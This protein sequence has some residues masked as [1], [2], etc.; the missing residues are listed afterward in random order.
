[1]EQDVRLIN[2]HNN[3][4]EP[5]G[6]AS[7]NDARGDSLNAAPV[8]WS[9]VGGGSWLG[10]EADLAS[11]TEY[12]S[13]NGR[14][15]VFQ[16]TPALRYGGFFPDTLTDEQM[17]AFI[18]ACE[19]REDLKCDGIEVMPPL[20][21]EAANEP[22]EAPDEPRRGEVAQSGNNAAST[23]AMTTE[24]AVALRSDTL[25]IAAIQGYESAL[26]GQAAS[27]VAASGDLCRL[28]GENAVRDAL[29]RGHSI[30]MARKAADD[31]EFDRRI[32]EA[33][34]RRAG[35]ACDGEP[36][37]HETP[38]ANIL[39]A[40]IA[41]SER[42]G[43][44]SNAGRRKLASALSDFNDAL[45]AGRRAVD[46]ARSEEHCFNDCCD[47]CHRLYHAVE[48][49]VR[50]WDAFDSHKGLGGE[51]GYQQLQRVWE[52]SLDAATQI[53]WMIEEQAAA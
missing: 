16:S 35:L 42:V 6:T 14:F 52:D 46:D 28:V 45:E 36:D 37:A 12:E 41:A 51:I 7:G 50:A 21:P 15:V 25:V 23:A 53:L 39:H 1:L 9:N 22:G 19:G 10:S 3:A 38:I 40:I 48:R 47:D 27:E 4:P 24:E 34:S 32:E 30:G 43:A 29:T 18:A 26:R 11:D 33:R 44:V 13:S 20:P 5:T 8:T 31:A 49:V 2:S 17:M